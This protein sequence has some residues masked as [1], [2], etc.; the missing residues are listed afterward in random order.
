M[1]CEHGFSHDGNHTCDDC[2]QTKA[3]FSSPLPSMEDIRDGYISSS[4]NP[5]LASHMFNLWVLA[6]R[7]RVASIATKRS[8]E[9]FIAKL[10][11]ILREDVW[12]RVKVHLS[13][14]EIFEKLRKGENDE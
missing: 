9:N 13:K 4:D 6:E 8:K 12:G 5:A 11:S 2:C 3:D 1:I 10:D 7:K 14:E